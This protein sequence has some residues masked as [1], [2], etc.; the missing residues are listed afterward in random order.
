MA[1][2]CFLRSGPYG[3]LRDD[4]DCYVLFVTRTV[5]DAITVRR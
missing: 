5:Y 2:F 4:T 3:L 1:N